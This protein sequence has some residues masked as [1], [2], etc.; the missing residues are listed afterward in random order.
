MSVHQKVEQYFI[1]LSA[2]VGPAGLSESQ[3]SRQPFPCWPFVQILE[4]QTGKWSRRDLFFFFL[5]LNVKE[6]MQK[7]FNFMKS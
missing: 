3:Q 7:K 6:N 2:S 4:K 5:I 1:C